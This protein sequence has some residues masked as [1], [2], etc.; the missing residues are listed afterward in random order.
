MSDHVSKIVM[1]G[2]H[3]PGKYLASP[4]LGIIVVTNSLSHVKYSTCV[5]IVDLEESSV[6][7]V[8][9]LSQFH[10]I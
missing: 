1:V 9:M 2:N 3:C 8:C 4:S 7:C 5:I 6:C 10:C